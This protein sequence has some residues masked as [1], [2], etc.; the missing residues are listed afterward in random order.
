MYGGMDTADLAAIY[1]YLHSV[2]P[3]KNTVV[4]F[5]PAALAKNSGKK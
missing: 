1:A 3:V 2:K 4:H 5:T